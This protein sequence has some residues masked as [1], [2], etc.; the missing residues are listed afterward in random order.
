MYLH[1]DGY[2]EGGNWIVVLFFSL[3]M[4]SLIE[5]LLSPNPLRI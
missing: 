1:V 4:K 3:F 2:R 5:S